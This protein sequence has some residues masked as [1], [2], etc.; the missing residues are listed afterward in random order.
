MRYA[1][2]EVLYYMQYNREGYS[3]FIS[4]L[5]SYAFTSYAH[6]PLRV[7][8]VCLCSIRAS[9][10]TWYRGGLHPCFHKQY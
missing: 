2:R 9:G 6:M 8:L 1:L 7:T 5:C 10:F 3:Q 4:E